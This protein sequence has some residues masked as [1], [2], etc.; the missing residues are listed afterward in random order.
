MGFPSQPQGNLIHN[1]KIDNAK[2]G[3]NYHH[4]AKRK[5]AISPR[6]KQRGKNMSQKEKL[7]LDELKTESAEPL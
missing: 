6:I 2:I 5:T 7:T 1:T 4:I 3:Y